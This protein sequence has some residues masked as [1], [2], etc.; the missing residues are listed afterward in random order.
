LG[1]K[2]LRLKVKIPDF[3][4]KIIN[5]QLMLIVKPLEHF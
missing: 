5:D 1:N 3:N 2:M 4:Y